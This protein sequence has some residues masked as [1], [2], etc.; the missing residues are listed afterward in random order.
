MMTIGVLLCGYLA[1]LQAKRIGINSEEMIIVMSVTLGMALL[2]A[3]LLYIFVSY[4]I[5]ELIENVFNGNFTFLK[6]GGLVFYGGLIGGIIGSIIALHWQQ[7]DIRKVEKCIVPVLPLGHAIGRIGC[8]FAGCCHGFEYNG[9]FAVKNLL[10]SIEKTYFPI[11]VVEAL[12]NLVIFVFLIWYAQKKHPTYH[13]LCFYL[14]LYSILRFILEF[15]R[16]DLIRGGFFALS[17]SQWISMVLF[18]ASIFKFYISKKQKR[19]EKNKSSTAL[20]RSI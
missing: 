4:S 10:I 13:I 11:Q 1:L 20:G 15:Y 2:G 17:T 6:N 16:G 14:F 12:L 18:L 8:L 7:L 9:L 5:R 3:G 19:K